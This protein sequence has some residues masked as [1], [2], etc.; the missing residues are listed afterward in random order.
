M[1]STPRK[2]THR[3][4]G[5]PPAIAVVASATPGFALGR[6]ERQTLNDKVYLEMREA[7]RRGQL[8]MGQALSLRSL[9]SM[10]GVSPMPVRDAV[11]RLVNE[12]VLETLPNRQV[13]VPHLTI[14]Q[15]EALTEARLANEGYAAFLAASRIDKSGL[16]AFAEANERLIK[17]ST[18]HDHEGTIQ[19]NRDVHFSIYRAAKSE[20]LLQ[21]IEN[22]WQQSGPYLA[23]IERAITSNA[24]IRDH[25]F[26]AMQHERIRRALVRRDGDKARAM[27]MTD[28][29]NFATIYRTLLLPQIDGDR[30]RLA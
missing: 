29:Q 25:D 1:S 19:A 12:C 23:T 26:G 14:A 28:I 3:E 11:A 27:L 17:T 15:Y 8:E 21:V 22:L 2:F 30:S 6:V 10:L 18:M 9:A 20:K 4:K 7:L 5:D 24:G 13:R 16:D